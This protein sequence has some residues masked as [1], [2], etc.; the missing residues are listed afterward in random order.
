MQRRGQRVGCGFGQC[1][2]SGGGPP[3]AL[4]IQADVQIDKTGKSCGRS[5]NPCQPGRQRLGNVSGHHHRDG[6]RVDRGSN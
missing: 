1:V 5:W 2:R 4:T 6:R 3:A